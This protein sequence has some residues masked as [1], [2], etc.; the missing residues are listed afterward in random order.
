MNDELILQSLERIERRQEE[1][2]V[3]IDVKIDHIGERLHSDEIILHELKNHVPSC[4]SR[5]AKLETADE[6]K[7]TKLSQN[8]LMIT[9]IISILS[10]IAGGSVVLHKMWVKIDN[11]HTTTTVVQP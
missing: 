7:R 6:R 5:F 3:K 11:I 9:L 10:A 1:I 8:L 2:E 4:E